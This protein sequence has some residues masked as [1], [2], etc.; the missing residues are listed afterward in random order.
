MTPYRALALCLLAACAG[1][2]DSATTEHGTAL[3]RVQLDLSGEGWQLWLDED[4]SWEDERIFAP[5]VDVSTL[6]VEPP[7]GGWAALGTAGR[8]VSVPGTVEQYTWSERGDYVGVSWWWRDFQ[9]PLLA[10]EDGTP[11][12]VVRLRFEA[13]RQRAEVFVNGLLV[14][15]DVV[16]NTPFEIDITDA[17]QAGPNQLAVRVT[18]PGGNFSWEDFDALAW[19]TQTLPA[20]HGFG[21]VTGPVS[22]CVLDPLHVADVFVKNTP[23]VSGADGPELEIDI[24]LRNAGQQPAACDV[25]AEIT[26]AADPSRVLF[27]GRLGQLAVLPGETVLSRRVTLPGARPWSPDDPQ[28]YRCRVTLYSRHGPNDAYAVTDSTSVR[29]GVR[30]LQIHG[31][32]DDAVLRL[33]GKRIVLRSAISWGF[34][35]TSGMVPSPELARRQVA[36]AKALGLNMLSHHR[37]IAA[38]GLLD[39]HDEL[40]LLAYA[41]PGGYTA[42]GG[43]EL[44]FALAREKLLR[45]VRRD[46]N[47]P[48][49]I[50]YNMINEELAE[51]EERHRRDMRDAHAADPTRTI[52]YTSGWSGDGEQ[53]IKLHMR[54]WDDDLHA[55][56]WWDFHNAPGP[57]VQRDEFWNGPDDYLRRSENLGEIVFWGEDGAIAAPPR[58]QLIAAELDST[59]PGWDGEHYAA[60]HRAWTRWLAARP[61]FPGLDELTRSLGDVALDYQART[62]ENIRLG[63]VADGY[64]VNGWEGERYENHSGIVDAWRHPKGN[65][66][67]LARYNAPLTLAVKL[68]RSVAHAGERVGGNIQ[69]TTTIVA[70]IGI[71][72]ELDLSGPH[73][74]VSRL[75]D[76]DGRSLWT[77]SDRVEVAGGETFGEL[78][79]AELTA[80]VELDPGRYTLHAELRGI[81]AAS[82]AASDAAPLAEGSDELLIVDWKSQALPG[83]GAVLESG[84]ALRRFA[85]THGGLD[86]EVFFDGLPPLDYV[87]I[88]DFD[89]EP[90][91]LVPA[92]ALRAPQGDAPG[93]AGEYFS[94]EQLGERVM[95]RSDAQIDFQWSRQGPDESLGRFH[96]SVRWSGRLL[97]PESGSYRLHA[98]SDDG[99]RVWLDGELLIDAWEA[100]SARS[101]RSRAVTMQAGSL[102]DLRVEY[103]Q[104]RGNAMIKL[105]WT[106]PSRSERTTALVDELLRRASEDG[107]RLAVLARADTWA[108]LFAE[109]GA[110]RYSGRLWHGRYWMGGGFFVREHPLFAGLPTGG[111]MGRPYQEL[112]NYERERFGLLLEGEEAVVGCFS[113]HQLELGTALGIVSHGRGQLLLSTLDVMPSLDRQSGAA[114]VVRKFVCNVVEWAGSR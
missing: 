104:Q 100:R 27:S 108:Q 47:H 94:D 56:G 66:E 20:S 52:T 110:V 11:P 21:G 26:D 39:A 35:P 57:G 3:P 49:L 99:V 83:R 97:A 63:N 111:A 43:D 65:A 102:H 86:L 23:R 5:P 51:P 106:T 85:G 24:T 69:L 105:S 107:T 79:V 72:N 2:S 4:A 15:Y 12:R 48:S 71:L 53:A 18:D 58:L 33:N 55:E 9:L 30:D 77:R 75:L 87:L 40:G 93:L 98:L 41:E 22:V 88:G 84:R 59:A 1:S 92:E 112:V 29:F 76:T 91:Q 81:D 25:L 103:R 6:A 90:Q 32:G 73:W 80:R 68:R 67:L 101:H 36:T 19:G 8:P 82:N 46:R 34:W 114:E 50:L 45:M 7:G 113:D 10:G 61:G 95:Q 60:R 54:P 38:P 74:L 70:D 31:L 78:L 28:L 42:H 64:V 16:G 44:C 62:I 37:T 109:A 13:V 14:G 17:V 89:I 96:Y